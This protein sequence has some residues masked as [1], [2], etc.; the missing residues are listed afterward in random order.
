[1]NAIAIKQME[2]PSTLLGVLP[3]VVY[4]EL[5]KDRSLANIDIPKGPY[6][7]WKFVGLWR[8]GLFLLFAG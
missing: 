2:L 8:A 1:M 4:A 6:L 7:V 5:S 3:H